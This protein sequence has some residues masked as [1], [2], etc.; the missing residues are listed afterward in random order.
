MPRDWSDDAENHSER[1]YEETPDDRE[2]REI[3][4][5]IEKAA[6]EA[7]EEFDRQQE[8]ER[9]AD[10][11]AKEFDE[12]E[13]RQKEI[14]DLAEAAAKEFDELQR[15]QDGTTE[16]LEDNLRNDID[17]VRD[18]LHDEY[19]NDMN[20]QLEG[21]SRQDGEV[22]EGNG[23]CA[24]SEATETSES[25]ED[26][27]A[28][29]VY[30][31]ETKSETDDDMRE[32][33]EPES[34]EPSE[35]EPESEDTEELLAEKHTNRI[36]R[37]EAEEG[38]TKT[39]SDAQEVNEPTTSGASPEVSETEEDKEIP[40][41]NKVH[42]ESE[43]AV[44]RI[45]QREYEKPASSE[46]E[47]YEYSEH[48]EL[49][50]KE[51]EHAEEDSLETVEPVETST[52]S[53]ELVQ[54]PE[55]S[56]E[57]CDVQEFDPLPKEESEVEEW[58]VE[59][60]NLEHEASES[61]EVETEVTQES[62][63]KE[64]LPEGPDDFVRRVKDLL[65]E[66]TEFDDY[67]D[68]VQD[69]LTGEIQKVP[70][71]LGEYETDEQRRRRKNRN[72]FAELSEEERELF[73][74]LVKKRLEDE[75][76]DFAGE[77][78]RAWSRVIESAKNKSDNIK[79]KKGDESLLIKDYLERHPYLADSPRHR[80]L[81]QYL[82]V[83][84][85]FREAEIST[86]QELRDFADD[87]NIPYQAVE[88]W[89]SRRSQSELL[90]TIESHNRARSKFV[91]E[92]SEK[93]R[94]NLLD[95]SEIYHSFRPLRD[96][97]KPSGKQLAESL[98]KL[99]SSLDENHRMKW[100]RLYPYHAKGP[101]WLK[102]IG[103]KLLERRED[104]ERA[105][106]EKFGLD[107]ESHKEIRVGIVGN[108]LYLRLKNTQHYAWSTLYREENFH[109]KTLEDKKILIITSRE[110]LGL[111]GNIEF[112]R[113]AGQIGDYSKSIDALNT[114]ADLKYA[115]SHISGG[116]LDLINDA[117]GQTFREIQN[118]IDYIGRGKRGYGVIRNPRLD[119]TPEEVIVPIVSIIGSDGHIEPTYH[120]RYTEGRPERVER[121][122]DAFNQ[123]VLFSKSD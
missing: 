93:A 103:E 89:Y 88:G 41:V 90:N 109:L 120:I 33:S 86:L 108:K 113:L 107:K 91:R 35:R 102:D 100:G 25:Y 83:Y 104:V 122:K 37:Q 43:P 105:L 98:A 52:E 44:S 30:A 73:K 111:K 27:G 23:E 81:S 53:E 3:P 58:L 99:C 55:E 97:L 71:I 79:N 7:A 92:L 112:G 5:E 67:Y 13:S 26:A 87:H 96:V 21:V 39:H 50:E 36:V 106:N 77:V 38:E 20:R 48:S 22:E 56:P 34:Q 42:S 49:K 28:E 121:V 95:P 40:E 70:M 85:E 75:E 69:P 14:E 6:Q 15:V 110:D 78:E 118:K 45:E 66:R 46:E 60:G 76:K 16:S 61:P 59:N 8:I 117:L 54:D 119:T 19:V 29:M 72:L 10:E 18:E 84:L 9:M 74:S 68:Y 123:F 57:F 31:M 116:T 94:E 62:V 47:G 2:S 17:E 101:M 114:N 11:A 65:D 24:S 1:E 32:V 51:E 82:N 63:E 12:W 64:T 4:D 80:K 115:N